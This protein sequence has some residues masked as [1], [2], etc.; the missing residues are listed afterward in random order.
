MALIIEIGGP[1]KR[2]A[3]VIISAALGPASGRQKEAGRGTWRPAKP[4]SDVTSHRSATHSAQVEDLIQ[5]R[6]EAKETLL[7]QPIPLGGE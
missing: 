3:P 1:D 6:H 7:L 5:G 4:F 2:V